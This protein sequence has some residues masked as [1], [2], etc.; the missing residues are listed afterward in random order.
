[1]NALTIPRS[2]ERGPIEAGLA[3][4]ICKL[5]VDIPRSYERGPIEARSGPAR[6]R[7]PLRPFRVHMNAAP[8]KPPYRS[9]RTHGVRPAFRV[10][11]NAAPL[12]QAPGGCRGH[13]NHHSAFI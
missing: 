7:F 12:K 3:H 9:A 2:Y 8:L 1:M 5:W 13:L 11:M 4:V 10:H 6:A